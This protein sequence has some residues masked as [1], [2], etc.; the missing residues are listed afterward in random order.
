MM[1]ELWGYTSRNYDCRVY[2]QGFIPIGV[3][4]AESTD[5]GI[6]LGAAVHGT[7]FIGSVFQGGERGGVFKG[8]LGGPY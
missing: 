3:I 5:I 8:T 4:T 7:T 6:I 1:R 2:R